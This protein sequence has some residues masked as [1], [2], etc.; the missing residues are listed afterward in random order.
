M[1]ITIV[2][3]CAQTEQSDAPDAPQ[4]LNVCR[5][6]LAVARR[7]SAQAVAAL[8]G[9]AEAPMRRLQR[10]MAVPSRGKTLGLSSGRKREG[11]GF[12]A[13]CTLLNAAVWSRHGAV[14]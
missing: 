3:G 1:P 12:L 13:P 14:G 10:V 5:D 8:S 11:G 2:V 4:M 9:C 7:D 6:L